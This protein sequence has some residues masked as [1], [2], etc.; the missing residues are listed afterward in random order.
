MMASTPL[1]ESSQHRRTKSSVLKAFIHKRTGSAGAALSPTTAPSGFNRSSSYHQNHEPMLFLPADHPHSRAL[2]ELENRQNASA[3]SSPKKRRDEKPSKENGE[4]PKKSLHKKTLSSISLK[5]L[6]EGSKSTK[7]ADGGPPSPKKNRSST[8]LAAL[9][10]R[11]KSSKSLNKQSAADELQS[12]KDKENRTPPTSPG[13]EAAKETPI[14]AQFCSDRFQTQPYGGKFV[15][16]EISL[17]TPQ[18]YSPDKQRNF[19]EGPGSQP[20]LTRRD[21]SR[22][23]SALYL[24]STFSLHDITRRVSNSSSKSGKSAKSASSDFEKKRPNSKWGSPF[25]SEPSARSDTSLPNRGQRILAAVS[26]FAS[27]SKAPEPATG[28]KRNSFIDDT[29]VDREFEAMLDRRNIPEH[30]RGKMRNLTLLMKKDF[31]RQDWAEIA[32]AKNKTGT[33]SGEP[34]NEMAAEPKDIPE[35]KVRRPR[36][37]TFT[38]SR[39]SSKDRSVSVKKSRPDSTLGRISRKKSSESISSTKSSTSTG[40]AVGSAPGAKQSPDDFTSY[41]RKVQKPEL[42]E[43][44]RLHKL[45]LLLRNET[46]A[47]T[48]DFI[49]QGGMVEIVGLLHRIMEIEWREEHED[50][51]L[52]EVLLCLKALATTDLALEHLSKIHSTLFPA[53]IHMLFDEE[54]KGPSEFTTRNIITSLL[55]TYLKSAPLHERTQRAEHLL[56]YLRDPEPTEENRPLEFVLDMRRSRPYRVWCKEVVNVTKE[57]FWIFLHNMNVIAL[58]DKA[59]F[60]KRDSRGS[61]TSDDNFL[62][63]AISQR[64]SF[65][66]FDPHHTYMKEH[67]PQER[68]PVPAAPYV[69]GVEWDATNYLASHLDLV[70]GILA[71]LPT[72]AARNALRQ[73]MLL[74]G[75]EKCMGSTLRLC[76]EKFYGSVHAGLRCWVA[77]AVDD[78]WETRDVR[79]G[80][81]EQ[82]PNPPPHGKRKEKKLEKEEAPRLSIKL[83][84]VKMGG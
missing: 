7:P 30:Q 76:K 32:A 24:P 43:V 31:I 23:P 5:S 62:P 53:L 72:K 13:P 57:V 81:S 2:K 69:G 6:L 8:N 35:G 34:N 71:S 51:L 20:S 36:S 59:R 42:V 25:A 56:S 64:S 50:A 82:K 27:R 74:S 17:Y 47:W 60:A 41:L 75:W 44:G 73:E 12:Q 38:L 11:P 10:S 58:P 77:A 37:R 18:E 78:E 33:N 45:R 22:R 67:F 61:T 52:H 49:K 79:C 3:Q 15:E 4:V 40:T 65:D 16:D 48:D 54:K 29:D 68:P 14:Y 9:L 19:Y 70:N 39:N 84:I 63:S 83:I 55:F 28:N 26:N 46:V 66:A 80:P 21:E 1:Q